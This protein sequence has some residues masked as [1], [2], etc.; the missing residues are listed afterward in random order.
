MEAKH[1]KR[2]THMRW[3]VGLD[4]PGDVVCAGPKY[5]YSYAAD[6]VHLLESENRDYSPVTVE[7]DRKWQIVGKVLWWIR[8]GP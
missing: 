3:Q 6:G 5:Q 2:L 7:K 8:K 1:A 4:H